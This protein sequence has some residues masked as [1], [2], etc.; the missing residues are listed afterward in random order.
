MSYENSAEIIL[1]A[2]DRIS[3]SGATIFG[4]AEMNRHLEAV[5]AEYSGYNPS[6]ASTSIT[7]VADQSLYTLPTGCLYLS[8]VYIDDADNDTTDTIA[9]ILLDI[10]DSLDNYDL[11]QLRAQLRERYSNYG[12]PVATWWNAQLYLHPAPTD[13]GDSIVVEYGKV[14]AKNS[15]GNYTTIPYDHISL[16]EDMLVCRC[17]QAMAIDAAMRVDYS[18]G[19]SRVTNSTMA[20]NLQK[21]ATVLRQRVDERLS[22]PIGMVA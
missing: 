21:M 11:H 16:I 8:R 15:S 7:T 3:D 2:R 19:Q 14:H 22:A 4:A 13:A 12:Q 1:R 18:D 9:D 17:L 10:R 5:V 6:M 20:Q